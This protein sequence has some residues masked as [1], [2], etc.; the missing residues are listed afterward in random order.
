MNKSINLGFGEIHNLL[1]KSYLPNIINAA[2]EVSVFDT[3]LDN[4]MSFAELSQ[5]IN[6]DDRIT[7]SLLEVLLSINLLYKHKDKY[8]LTVQ[9]KVYL[10]QSSNINQLKS[11]KKFVVNEGPFYKLTQVLQGDIPKFEQNM[12]STEESIK[13]IEQGSKTGAIQNVV[14]FVREIPEFKNARRMCDFA[15]N[16][17]YYSFSLLNENKELYASVYD[18]KEVCKI[19]LNIKNDEHDFN[20]ISYHDLDLT[21][22]EYWG[23][24]YDLFFSSHYLYK[25]VETE[26]L[27]T[28]ILKKINRSM[29]IGGLFVSNHM[30]GDSNVESKTT[31]SILE[32][33]TR[34]MGFFGH[35]IPKEIFKQALSKAGFGKFHIKE[36]DFILD[37]PTLLLA[38][39]KIEEA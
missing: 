23:N 9:S 15:G 12:W 6:T 28:E 34:A 16:S 3:L 17:G 32:L 21:K 19:A 11:I 13:D 33:M 18:L 30:S 37:Y 27:L 26:E 39:I 8:S 2:V 1:F 20:R 22:E 35:C 36:P 31:I 5:K 7:E 38:A 24:N 25:Y 29:K 10:T 4:A 14:N